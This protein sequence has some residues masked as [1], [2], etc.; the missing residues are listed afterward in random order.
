MAKCSY[1]YNMI[2]F[3]HVVYTDNGHSNILIQQ[4]EFRVRRINQQKNVYIYKLLSTHIFQEK[5]T[6]SM[7][8]KRLLF[9]KIFS[10]ESYKI[11]SYNKIYDKNGISQTVLSKCDEKMVQFFQEIIQK[12]STFIKKIVEYDDVFKYNGKYEPHVGNIQ[13]YTMKLVKNKK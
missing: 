13:E 12:Y 3:N 10:G 1:G 7:L 4:S 2:K 6:H 11:V 8:N 5:L 9:E